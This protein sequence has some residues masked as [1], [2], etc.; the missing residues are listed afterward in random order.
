MPS[1]QQL[2]WSQVRVGI[3]VIFAAITLAVLIFLMSGEIGIFSSKISLLA[4]FDNTEGV[5]IGA[6]VALQGVTIG[7]VKDVRV[8]PGRKLDPVQVTMKVNTKYQFLLRKDT[9]ASIETAGVLGESFVDLDSKDAKGQQAQDGDVL[10]SGS[11]PG[12][13]DVVRAGQ[14]TLGN[15]D[16]LVKSLNRIVQ[17]IETGPGTLH[18]IISDSTL[19]NRANTI[20][21]QIQS[22]INDVNGG[23]GTIGELLKDNTTARKLNA[24]LDKLN[25]IIDDINAGKGNA[26]LLL[27]DRALYDNAS[28]VATKA[29]KLMDDIN[30]GRGMIGKLTKDEVFAKKLDDI[31]DKL[32]QITARLN[33]TSH[34]GSLGLFIQNPSFYNNTDQLLTETRNLI[35]AI[36]ENPKKYLTI[37]LK[38]F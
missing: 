14:T 15:L 23:K 18:D 34:P 21:A 6:P 22:L 27:K 3:T 31:V 17:Q 12:L 29:N 20:L 8:V 1:Q 37:H 28:Q 25:A 9:I 5:K 2:K 7:N 32:S 13:Q 10:K 38:V 33:D 4:Y 16:I 19:V 36:R 26:G 11:A 24:S 30:S 35:T